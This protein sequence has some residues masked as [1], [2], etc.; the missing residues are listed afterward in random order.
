METKLIKRN[1][2]PAQLS[3]DATILNKLTVVSRLE[4]QQI[5]I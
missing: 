2:W 5:I 4:S 3:F 1:F